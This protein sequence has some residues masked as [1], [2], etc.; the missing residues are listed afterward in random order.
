MLRRCDGADVAQSSAIGL[1][2]KA[3][4]ID[5]KGLNEPVDWE[6]LF[7]LPKDF[8]QDEVANLEKYFTEQFGNDL[9]NTIS[10]ELH[11]LKIRVNDM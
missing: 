3:D 1:I 4:S 8:W 11:N 7:S 10:E 9:P 5:M 2:P 6:Q